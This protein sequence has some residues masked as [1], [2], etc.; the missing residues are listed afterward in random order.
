MISHIKYIFFF[1]FSLPE[2]KQASSLECLQFEGSPLRSV[3]FTEYPH[4][5]PQW[6]CA[7]TKDNSNKA[8]IP[9]GY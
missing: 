8:S 7:M 3:I 1:F 2:Q 4:E 6:V 5:S 9:W